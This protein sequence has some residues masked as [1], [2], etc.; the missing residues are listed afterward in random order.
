MQPQ[1]N[2]KECDGYIETILT[3]KNLLTTPQLN[4]STAFS[5]DELENLG[6][7]G[8]VPARIETLEEQVSR[9][10]LQYSQ[11][12]DDLQKHIYLNNLHDKNQVLFYKLVSDHLT[13]IFP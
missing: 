8:K 12:K 3:G 6:L 7:L 13:E 4:K 2:F 5:L 9:A 11:Y 1:P 10:Y